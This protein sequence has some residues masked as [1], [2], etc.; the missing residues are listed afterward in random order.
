MGRAVLIQERSRATRLAIMNIAED[1]WRR[2][3]FDEVSVEQVCAKAGVAKGTFYFYFPR[4]EHLLVM[5]VFG[6][7]LPKD[8]DLKA[9]L[10]SDLTTG[11]I[12]AQ[13]VAGVAARVRRMDRDLVQKGVEESFRHFREIGRLEGGDRSL[14]Y[15]LEPIFQRGVARGEVNAEW[16][17]DIVCGQLGWSILQEVFLWGSRLIPG[18]RMGPH[19]LERA[20]LI[21]GGAASPRALTEPAARAAR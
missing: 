11:E 8:A 18:R 13:L 15:Y 12:C 4:K 17:L 9:W 19:L 20:R 2:H 7:M 21:V 10:A 3:G 6:R 14:R 16:R 5:L 1:L